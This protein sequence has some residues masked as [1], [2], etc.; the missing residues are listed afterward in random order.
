MDTELTP[1]QKFNAES[2]ET[3]VP[4]AL[5][6]G[7]GHEAIIADLMRL[8]WSPKAAQKLVER[9]ARD[10]E[11]YQASPESRAALVKE[12]RLQMLGGLFMVFS[13]LI[14]SVLSFFMIVGGLS[15]VG[16]SMGGAIIIGLMLAHRGHSRW[17]L[18]RRDTLLSPRDN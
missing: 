18:Y 15:D 4:R 14:I 16:I 17:R 11:R 8:D 6:Q 3:M 2:P 1:E 7:Q 5:L 10:I 9:V 13:G 12:C